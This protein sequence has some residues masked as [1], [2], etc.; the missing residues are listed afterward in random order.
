M[1]RMQDNEQ[2]T[3]FPL[4]YG[5]I[6]DV[7]S[8]EQETLRARAVMKWA[9][10]HS[11][12]IL[13]C[14]DHDEAKLF[15]HVMDHWREHHDAPSRKILEALVRKDDMP[16]AQL[17]VLENYDLWLASAPTAP[18]PFRPMSGWKVVPRAKGLNNGPNGNKKTI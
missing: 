4:L 3:F 10:D 2:D 6:R 12:A 16:E 17:S 13:N 9:G 7:P 1:S 14:L 15:D 8:T 5:M 11:P 18:L